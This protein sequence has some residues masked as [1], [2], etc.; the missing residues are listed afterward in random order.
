MKTHH[1]LDVWQKSI[2]IVLKVYDQTKDFPSYEKYGLT[3]Q[4][5]RTAVSIPSN[6][7]E[8][9][10]RCSDKKFIK[11]LYYSLASVSEL[12][13][14]LI[15]SEKL[16]FLKNTT[17]LDELYKNKQIISGLIRYLKNKIK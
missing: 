15:L 14:Q 6:I 4:M 8:G 11:F 3:S 13:T 5:R 1:D 7:A 12:E 16:G 9:A 10:A 2:D 17:L